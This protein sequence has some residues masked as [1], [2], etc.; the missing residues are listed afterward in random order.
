MGILWRN[1]YAFLDTVYKHASLFRSRLFMTPA[2]VRLLHILGGSTVTLG[3]LRDRETSLP[4]TLIVSRGRLLRREGF[5][6]RVMVAG[7]M[8]S[9]ANA[10]GLAI[11]LLQGYENDVLAYMEQSEQL[12]E[13]G[14]RVCYVPT[15]L[16]R[17]SKAVYKQVIGAF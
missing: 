2:E 4:V 14:W 1:Y 16:L 8:L 11:T 7:Q 10:R 6:R 13:A 12:A 5:K 3:F 17:D 15:S 9:F